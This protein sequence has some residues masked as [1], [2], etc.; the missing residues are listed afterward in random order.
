MGLFAVDV[1]R[2]CTITCSLYLVVEVAVEFASSVHRL[3]RWP[4]SVILSTGG[5]ARVVPIS[6]AAGGAVR[7]NGLASGSRCG[8]SELRRHLEECGSRDF[9]WIPGPA[10]AATY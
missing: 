9:G 5:S 6:L 3:A 7:G 1:R 8:V 2:K 10:P 4:E